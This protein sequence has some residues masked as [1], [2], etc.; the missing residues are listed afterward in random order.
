LL[1]EQVE[2]AASF[3]ASLS[4]GGFEQNPRLVAAFFHAIATG[5]EIGE[6]HLRSDVAFFDGGPEQA[7]G[8]GQIAPAM[9][10]FQDIS[11]L[12]KLVKAI[13]TSR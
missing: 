13:P 12:L 6:R 4:D 5:V 9:A 7:Y 10:S 8:K 2:A 3:G 11:S 1:L